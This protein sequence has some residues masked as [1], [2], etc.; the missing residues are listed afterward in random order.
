MGSW[1]WCSKSDGKI[2]Y[3]KCSEEN[4][5]CCKEIILAVI[6]HLLEHGISNCTKSE[7]RNYPFWFANMVYNI[8]FVSVQKNDHN[9]E[10]SNINKLAAILYETFTNC[11]TT[12]FNNYCL[13]KS[14]VVSGMWNIA[15]G[16]VAYRIPL[17][18]DFMGEQDCEEITQYETVLDGKICTLEPHWES[19]TGDSREK[20][21]ARSCE[22][23]SLRFNL[24]C[25][26]LWIRFLLC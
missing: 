10:L 26:F 12:A 8:D 6:P 2:K 21:E 19:T 5:A 15:V 22:P 4:F 18:F 25:F 1:Y 20:K 11:I 16:G 17:Q 13:Y 7:I 23:G 9:K 24:P 14:T 3:C